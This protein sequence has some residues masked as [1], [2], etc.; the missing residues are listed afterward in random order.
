[1]PT[2]NLRSSICVQHIEGLLHSVLCSP[3]REDIREDAARAKN[4][5]HRGAKKYGVSRIFKRRKKRLDGK[6]LSRLFT[7]FSRSSWLLL[8]TQLTALQCTAA[9]LSQTY[10][11]VDQIV[12]LAR[13]DDKRLSTN[14]SVYPCNWIYS[15]LLLSSLFH[16][17]QYGR[18][19]PLAFGFSLQ[20]QIALAY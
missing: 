12:V 20:S 5:S 7:A 8:T 1:M 11:S 9:C 13:P 19:R 3:Q 18:A 2:G 14:S 6:L 15:I 10:G 16:G 4:Q 17:R